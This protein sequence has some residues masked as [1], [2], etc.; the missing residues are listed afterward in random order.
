M[1]TSN[2]NYYYDTARVSILSPRNIL[3]TSAFLYPNERFL[4]QTLGQLPFSQSTGP[5]YDYPESLFK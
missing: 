2:P 1:E 4:N 5:F 3:W